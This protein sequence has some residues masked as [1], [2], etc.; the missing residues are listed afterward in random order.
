M[1][2][3]KTIVWTAWIIVLVPLLYVSTCSMIATVKT[4]GFDKVNKGN[5]E[6]QVIEALGNPSVREKSGGVPFRRYTA[7]A[8]EAPCV[9]RFWFE[10]RMG[11]DIEAWSVEF[12][13]NGKVVSKSHLTSP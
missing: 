12:D 6:Q 10:N 9:E 1:A 3:H 11:M 8:C 4:R 13:G 2:K 7:Y 5:T